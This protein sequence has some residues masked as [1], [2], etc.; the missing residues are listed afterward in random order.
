MVSRDLIPRRLNS[1]D[2]RIAYEVENDLITWFG[3]VEGY[4][5]NKGWSQTSNIDGQVHQDQ[6][7]DGTEANQETE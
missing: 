3:Y 4:H 1:V 5:G 2:E 7:P 6:T